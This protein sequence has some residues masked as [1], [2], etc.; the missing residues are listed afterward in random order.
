VDDRSFVE[1]LMSAVPEAFTDPGDRERYLDEPLSYVALG[2][3][4][5][6]LEDNALRI[7]ML[8]MRARVR[9]EDVDVL[10]R[11]LGLRRGA[12]AERQGRQLAGDAVA[13]P[14]L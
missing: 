6:W 8:P 2:H 3:V 7:S 13:D 14:V 9:P 10:R 1:S 4:R 5:I 12:G 11:L